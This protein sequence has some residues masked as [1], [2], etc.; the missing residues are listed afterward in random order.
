MTVLRSLLLATAVVA[1]ASGWTR[2]QLT[3]GFVAT[4]AIATDCAQTEAL[5]DAGWVER[6]PLLGRR[7]TDARL[8]GSCAAGAAAMWIVADALPKAR[9][10]LFAIVTAVELAMIGHNA[11]WWRL[12]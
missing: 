5:L 4:G 6:N 11:Q 1:C 9:F 12:W 8:W 7:P 2:P 3:V 10:P